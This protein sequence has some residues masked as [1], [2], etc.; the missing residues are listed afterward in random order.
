MFYGGEQTDQ[1]QRRYRRHY[2]ED[3]SMEIS[4][5]IQS[6]TTNFVFYLGGDAYNAPAIWKEEH[7]IPTGMVNR[8]LYYLHRD[9]QGTILQTTNAAGSIQDNRLF[10]AWGNVLKI[11]TANNRI[12]FTF[13][14]T[15]RGYTGH[16]HLLSV[17]IIH[18]NGRLYD[19]FLHRF[20]S[21]DNYVQDPTNTQNF[22]RYG[23]V[24]N[25]PLT[26]IDPSGE[27]VFAFLIPVLGKFF[28]TVVSSAIVG[29]AIGV[30]G[31][32]ASVAFS[33]GGFN[34]WNW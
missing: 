19:P 30:A 7:I 13:L 3:G 31:Y 11:T 5:D 14:V 8:N 26:R 22:N 23:Y 9:Y 16:E 34:N 24:M 1:T 29:A 15:D 20:L 32:T 21:P 17:G 18:M 10:D 27:I 2:S 4:N 25:N 12:L 28:A 6:N 33:D